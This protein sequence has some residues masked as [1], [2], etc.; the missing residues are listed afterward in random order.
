MASHVFRTQVHTVRGLH[1]YNLFVAVT[2]ICIQFLGAR[3]RH[4]TKHGMQHKHKHKRTPIRAPQ[5]DGKTPD[6]SLNR[7][8]FCITVHE[9]HRLRRTSPSLLP[10]SQQCP[11]ILSAKMSAKE[12][13]YSDVAEHNTK[14][15]LFIVV[16]DKVYNASSFVDEHP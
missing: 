1:H 8:G 3:G 12:F 16:H 5:C 14:K 7:P 10:S 15:D 11:R 2:I 9:C 13:T 6:M 4:S